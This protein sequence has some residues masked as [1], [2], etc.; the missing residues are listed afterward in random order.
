MGHYKGPLAI[1][2]KK[3]INQKD[4]KREKDLWI[5]ICSKP[6]QKLEFPPRLQNLK[7]HEQQLQLQE[8]KKI[9]TTVSYTSLSMSTI[10]RKYFRFSFS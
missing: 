7:G 4:D 1:N 3:Q 6:R 2:D 5:R 10:P 8:I 9:I